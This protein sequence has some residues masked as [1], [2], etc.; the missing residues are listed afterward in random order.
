MSDVLA[1]D[2]FK[3]VVGQPRAV[4]QLRAALA[5]PVHAYLFVGPPG[6]SKAAASLGFAAGLVCPNGGC[7]RCDSCARAMRGVHPDI[8]TIER[9]GAAITVDE[10]RDVTTR[11][12]RRPVEG[13]RQV[14]IVD[15]VHL[16]LRSAPALLKTLEEPPAT[17]VFVLTAE[18][19]P[20]ALATISSRCAVITFSALGEAEVT[21][22]LIRRGVE[23]LHARLVAAGAG[24]DLQR[25]ELL[26][27]DVNYQERLA[28]WRDVPSRLDGSGAAAA[29]A[30]EELLGS[31]DDAL[32][33]LRRHHA[34]ELSSLE[35]EARQR[36]E[37]GLPGRKEIVD[38]HQRAERRWRTDELRSGLASLQRAYRDRLR[39]VL[40]QLDD[41]PGNPRLLDEARR[42]AMAVERISEA[43]AALGRNVQAPL[44]LASLLA[45]LG[46]TG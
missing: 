44:L 46:A 33:P 14:L 37:R 42:D 24:G 30:A 22:W 4:A 3:D 12:L 26:A 2:L 13:I 29:I 38:R 27:G 39:A 18:D 10:I 21:D 45:P 7:G 23:P 8:S 19:V 11:A 16:A 34:A 25:A 5:R 9:T 36:G 28:R 17:T 15:D 40:E 1:A 31:L 6:S 32:E 43:S 20:P 41:Q 35:D